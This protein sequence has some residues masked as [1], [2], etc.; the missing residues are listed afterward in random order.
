MD[1]N[2]HWYLGETG[3]T[4]LAWGSVALLLLALVVILAIWVY[5]LRNDQVW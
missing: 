3:F 2:P 1:E 5:E 4:I